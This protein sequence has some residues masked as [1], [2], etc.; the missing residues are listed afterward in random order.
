MSNNVVI[1]K[2]VSILK[3]RSEFV[4]RLT[5]AFQVRCVAYECLGMLNLVNELGLFSSGEYFHFYEEYIY[6]MLEKLRIL[7]HKENL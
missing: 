4:S 6:P 2:L 3:K 5:S 1:E 7:E